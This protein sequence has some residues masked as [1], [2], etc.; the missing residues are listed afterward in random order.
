MG[1]KFRQTTLSQSYGEWLE[2]RA[3]KEAGKISKEKATIQ[4][5]H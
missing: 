4:V 5:M 2:E 3:G 1:V